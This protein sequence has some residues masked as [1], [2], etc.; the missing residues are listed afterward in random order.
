MP[1]RQQKH[2]H[3]TFDEY[4]ALEASAEEEVRYEFLDGIV[5]AMSGGSMNHNEIG[6]NCS[7]HLRAI[8]RPSSCWVFAE[9]VK[10]Q[11]AKNKKYVYPDVVV[12]CSKEDRQDGKI[13]QFPVIIVEVLSDSTA[14]KDLMAKV[15]AY[16]ALPELKAYIII[17]QE[18]CWIRIYERD[19][20]GQ[21][22]PHR[23]L[24]N[25]K[26]TLTI[27]AGMTWEIPVN[28][29]YGGIDFEAEED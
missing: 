24:T 15:I 3:L 2:F 21:W 4:E 1:I 6:Q 26:E 27:A 25:L 18:D 28:W 8:F 9:N 19:N 14:A 11:V 23:H 16:Q 12:T 29:I 22:A 13:V 20:Q 7:Q 17:S 5:Y 10:V